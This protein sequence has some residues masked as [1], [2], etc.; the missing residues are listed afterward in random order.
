MFIEPEYDFLSDPF[1]AALSQAGDRYRRLNTRIQ[2]LEAQRD[3]A[4]EELQRLQKAGA[5]F[6]E[7]GFKDIDQMFPDGKLLDQ[8]ARSIKRT[9]PP[10]SVELEESKKIEHALTAAG[11]EDW[12]VTR[13]TRE[14]EMDCITLTRE[15]GLTGSDIDRKEIR[16]RLSDSTKQYFAAWRRGESPQ[17]CADAA[18]SL[19]STKIESQWDAEHFKYV[20]F[21]N[22]VETNELREF[23]K[24]VGSPPMSDKPTTRS[25]IGL[26]NDLSQARSHDPP[27][28]Y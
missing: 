15:H 20:A 9:P 24:Q 18:M 6:I 26:W 17:A 13:V 25:G 5:D 23:E 22:G 21:Y 16:R 2:K 27:H 28:P 14:E 7:G 3:E 1:T 19:W 11:I 4:Y 10:G 12:K 8:V